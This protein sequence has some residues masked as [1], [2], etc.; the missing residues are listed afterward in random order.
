MTIADNAVGIDEFIWAGVTGTR[1]RW[2]CVSCN[3]SPVPN[4]GPPVASSYSVA[5]SAYRSA[6]WSTDRPVRP[7]CSGAKYAMV[8][9]ISVECV[10]SGRIWAAEVANP[11]STRHGVALSAITMLAGLMSRCIT[12]RPCIPATALANFRASAIRSSTESGFDSP[13]RLV[14]PASANTIDPVYRASSN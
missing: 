14:P 11:K 9:T 4:G 13:A 5:P 8:P 7:V 12:P 6:R 1:A 10:N 2:S 3:G